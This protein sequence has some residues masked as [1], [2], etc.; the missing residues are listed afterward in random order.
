MAKPGP[1]PAR[2]TP[3]TRPPATTI[4]D[5]LADVPHL[6][7]WQL[8]GPLRMVRNAAGDCPLIA[9]ARN[10]GAWVGTKIG[11]GGKV[12]PNGQADSARIVAMQI[13]M[14]EQDGEDLA[15]AADGIGESYAKVGLH[16]DAAKVI[17][18]RVK[19]LAA[20]GLVEVPRLK[21]VTPTQGGEECPRRSA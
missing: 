20:C 18:L 19:V 4:A 2:T 3:A 5:V 15:D 12:G 6:G 14:T 13:G 17:A 11:T 10:R 16:D 8:V 1:K 9:F 21:R 7:P